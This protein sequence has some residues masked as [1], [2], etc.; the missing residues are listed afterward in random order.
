MTEHIH[1]KSMEMYAQDAR[2]TDKPWE[3]WEYLVKGNDVVWHTHFYHPKWNEEVKYRRKPQKVEVCGMVFDDIVLNKQDAPE[4]V[5]RVSVNGVVPC[6]PALI[7]QVVFEEGWI[8]TTYAGAL[9]HCGL[10]IPK[11][12]WK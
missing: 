8:H 11:K 10:L 1:A 3:R 4:T 2:E 5:Y 6:D 7:N 12:A 9:V